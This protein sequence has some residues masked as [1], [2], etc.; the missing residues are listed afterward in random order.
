[1]AE[2]EQTFPRLSDEQVTRVAA[3]AT[4][5][6]YAAGDLVWEQGDLDAPLYVVIEGELEIVHPRGAAVLHAVAQ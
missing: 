1:M 2:E 3:V 6:S 5:R 4:L